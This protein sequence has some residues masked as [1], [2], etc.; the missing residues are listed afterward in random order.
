MYK[1][2]FIV[3]VDS[4]LENLIIKECFKLVIFLF[5]KNKNIKIFLREVILVK[6]VIIIKEIKKKYM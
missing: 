1:K 3:N 4:S 6:I 5:L 2:N